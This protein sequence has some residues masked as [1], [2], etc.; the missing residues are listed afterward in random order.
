V[1]AIW[2]VPIFAVAWMASTLTVQNGRLAAIIKA[3]A[4]ARPVDARSDEWLSP[5]WYADGSV[6]PD[7]TADPPKNILLI[8]VGD[9]C[10][11]CD[12]ALAKWAKAARALPI[13]RRPAIRVAVVGEVEP[14]TERLLQATGAKVSRIRDIEGVRCRLGVRSVPLSLLASRSGGLRVVVVGVPSDAV[15]GHAMHLTPGSSG[16]LF[17][18]HGQNAMLVSLASSVN[19]VRSRPIRTNTGGTNAPSGQ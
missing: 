8:F 3:G 15:M 13:N 4:S 19:A 9:G 17:T 1:L 18:E 11:S 7:A 5:E 14:K 12:E 16:P 2:V 6:L 10:P